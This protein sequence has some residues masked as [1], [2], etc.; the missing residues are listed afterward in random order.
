MPDVKTSSHVHA[1]CT[2]SC[3][4]EGRSDSADSVN[5]V[6]SMPREKGEWRKGSFWVR[7]CVC[8]GILSGETAAAISLACAGGSRSHDARR[9]FA[10]AAEW[11]NNGV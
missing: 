9:A 8:H 3:C 4:L 11:S 6:K 1:L 2:R 5:P 7:E 10:Q